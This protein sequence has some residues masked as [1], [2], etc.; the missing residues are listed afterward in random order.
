[1]W[2]FKEWR[3][4]LNNISKLL[5]WLTKLTCCRPLWDGCTLYPSPQC[6]S[7]SLATLSWQICS[8]FPFGGLGLKESSPLFSAA[9]QVRLNIV[10]YKFLHSTYYYP[11][12]LLI[13]SPYFA[14]LSVFSIWFQSLGH[15][16][17]KSRF[18]SK[19]YLLFPSFWMLLIL[20]Q[21]EEECW[22]G[23]LS[24]FEKEIMDSGINGHLTFSPRFN[25]WGADLDNL[26][27]GSRWKFL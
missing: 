20:Q 11:F 3:I 14:Y 8:F 10:H 13:C 24:P 22:K 25:K 4:W 1:M 26:P 18:G 27:L 12:V 7:A 17:E 5:A 16:F 21:W 23:V 9:I 15:G 2:R 6:A 19:S